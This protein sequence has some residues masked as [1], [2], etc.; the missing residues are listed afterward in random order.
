MSTITGAAGAKSSVGELRRELQRLE[1]GFGDPGWRRHVPTGLGALDAALP[2]GGIPAG[3]VVEIDGSR[4]P[5]WTL[6]LLIARGIQAG[7]AAAEAVLIDP[8]GSLYPPAL[9]GLGLDLARVAFVRPKPG[10]EALW[11]FAEALAP[12]GSSTVKGCAVAVTAIGAGSAA[13]ARRLQLAAETGGGIGLVL[14]AGGGRAV[15]RKAVSLGVATLRVEPRSSDDE[16]ERW[17]IEVVRCRGG[18]AGKR[19]IV[20]VDRATLS[21]ASAAV[22]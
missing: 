13:D 14:G 21:I 5:P 6:A 9:A 10:R 3:S 4:W 15:R 17:L 12:R 2:G 22:L 7:D 11:A 18:P 8:E 19:A 16:R 1:G 20:E